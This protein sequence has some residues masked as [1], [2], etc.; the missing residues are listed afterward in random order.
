MNAE[1]IPDSPQQAAEIR[2]FVRKQLGCSCPDEVFNHIRVTRQPDIFANLP[3]DYLLEIGNRLLIAV[4]S[5]KIES[6]SG[7]L[8]Q[9]IDTARQYRDSRRFNRFRMVVASSDSEAISALQSDFESLVDKDNKLHLHGVDA[10][11]LPGSLR[12]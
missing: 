4:S 8:H 2:E 5:R 6:I 9:I 10:A 3:V 11:L 7:S 12:N 1:N